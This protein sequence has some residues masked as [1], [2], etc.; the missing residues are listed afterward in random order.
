MSKRPLKGYVPPDLLLEAGKALE[1]LKQI[2]YD[3]M[4]I[5]PGDRV[6]DL[7]CGAG[8]DIPALCH[9]VGP[10]G[11]V[12]GWDNDPEMLLKITKSDRFVQ[13]TVQL[14][15]ISAVENLVISDEFNSI[16]ADRLLQ[17]LEDPALAVQ[18][19]LKL[20]KRGGKFVV[21]DTDWTSF[22]IE[23]PEKALERSISGFVHSEGVASPWAA[24]AAHRLFCEA[25]FVNVKSE[26]FVLRLSG[27]DL[28]GSVME[29]MEDAVV[30]E[31]LLSTNEMARW[32][33]Y[34]QRAFEGGYFYSSLNF[35][36]TTGQKSMFK[37]P[38]Y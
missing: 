11:E 35:V 31:G 38:G 25:G 36:I 32:R 29:E 10:E 19:A 4:K 2:S 37:V 7:G 13:D 24:K 15:R 9:L 20:L 1:P 33:E 16:R 28:P 8:F 21:L 6:L 18:N 12:H 26:T 3:R 22:T 17:H 27:Q 14:A 5:R 23:C 34:R 30:S